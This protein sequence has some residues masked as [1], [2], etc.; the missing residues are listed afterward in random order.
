MKVSRQQFAANRARILE[1]AAR[2]FREKGIDGVGL[3]AVMRAAGLTHGAFYSHF[4]SKDE[5]VAEA[6]TQA[7][8]GADAS[9]RTAEAP[10][11]ALARAYLTDTHCTNRAEGCAF[12]AL[13]GDGARQG[14]AVRA[15]LGRGL[16]ERVAALASALPGPP[17]AARRRALSTWAGLVGTLVLARAVSDPAFAREILRAGRAA[18]GA[19]PARR[20]RPVRSRA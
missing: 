13:G 20:R 1:A 10:A 3:D 9:W 4:G 16:E 18:F 11:A 5:L 17:A 19:V 12:A 2:L 14:R 15:A 7:L 8:A 6:C